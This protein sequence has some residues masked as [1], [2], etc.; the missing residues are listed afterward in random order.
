MHPFIS[1]VK[2]EAVTIAK[3]I[4]SSQTTF[5]E[6]KMP[7]VLPQVLAL[8]RPGEMKNCDLPYNHC[9]GHD[10]DES[11]ANGNGHASDLRNVDG[12]T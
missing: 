9:R 1:V 10:D 7:T 12:Y 8:G 11:D 4:P 6:G 2:S 3:W 5:S